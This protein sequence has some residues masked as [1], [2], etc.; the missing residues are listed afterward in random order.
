MR[1]FL[2]FVFVVALSLGMMNVCYG[3][4]TAV[5]TGVK[6]HVVADG[7]EVKNGLTLGSAPMAESNAVVTVDGEVVINDAHTKIVEWKAASR[8]MYA[9][10]HTVAGISISA[11]YDVE[12]YSRITYENLKGAKNSNPTIYRNGSEVSLA[13]LDA[14]AGYTFA[15]WTPSVITADMVGDLTVTAN[16]KMN[17]Y[18]IKYDANGGEGEMADTTCAYD[19]EVVA[20]N[21]FTMMDREVAGWA[22]EKGGAVVYAL[23]ARVKGLVP[24]QDGCITLYAVWMDK[25]EILDAKVTMIRP[26]G[27]AIDFG[28][29]KIEASDPMRRLEILMSVDG[30]NYVAKNLSGEMGYANGSHRVY[31]NMAKD[32]ITL[33][34]MDAEVEVKYGFAPYCVI[35]LSKG[36]EDGV[37]YPVTYLD[38]EPRGGFNTDVYKTSKLVLKRVDAGSFIMGDDQTNESHRVTLTKPFYMGIFEVTQKQWELVMGTNPSSY[39]TDGTMKPVERVSYNMIRGSAKGANWPASDEVDDDS[40][41]G[42][43][44]KRTGIKFDLPAEAQ[45]EYTCR[46]GTTTKYSYGDSENGGYMWYGGN[47]GDFGTST[48]GTKEVGTRKANPWGFYDMHGNVFEWCLDWYGDLT[49]GAGMNCPSSGSCRVTRGG[50]WGGPASNCYSFL[51]RW[52]EPSIKSLNDGF[53]LSLTLP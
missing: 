20:S 32:G 2:E 26:W 35:D 50:S 27:L 22:T 15:G 30:T 51:R 24:D 9:V 46:A 40:F 18:T 19:E 1:R 3:G 14:V 48:C 29:T 13:D 33:D 42:R 28:V 4:A 8:G 31:W 36:A 6:F 16:W 21:A 38:A 34:T 52:L 7:A 10:S 49:Y 41:L 12:M 5:V 39:K 23:D 44:R 11:T 17:N 45:W 47:D 53:R 37:T 43:L 25:A